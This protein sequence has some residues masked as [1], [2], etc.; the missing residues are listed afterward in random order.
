MTAQDVQEWMWFGNSD[1]STTHKAT[2]HYLIEFLFLYNPIVN[3]T[4][5]SLLGIEAIEWVS[6]SWASP[7]RVHLPE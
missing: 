1:G 2:E 7:L 3:P 6:N 5:T 4:S